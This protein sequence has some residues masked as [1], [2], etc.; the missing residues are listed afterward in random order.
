M[1]KETFL[2]TDRIKQ[3][4]SS[5]IKDGWVTIYE[6]Y[7]I[8]N[9]DEGLIYCCLVDS[10]RI[11]TYKQ[12]SDWV[13][14]IGSEGK[15]SIIET[16]KNSK[17]IVKYHTY[18]EKGI[19]PFVFSKHFSFSDGHDSYVD[20]SEEFILYFKLYEKGTDKQNRK[21]YFIDDGGD[22]EEVIIFEPKKVKVKVKYLI[23]YISV[24]KIYFA[25]CFDF[26]RLAKNNLSEL[27]IELKDTN[28]SSDLIYYNHLIRRLDFIDAGKNQSWI[29]G[30]VIIPFNKKKTK[31]YHFDYRNQE[32]A[33]FI[34]GY[35][36]K[37]NEI[38]QSCKKED[39]KHFVLT[40]FKKE[41]LNKYY[42]EP[43]KYEVDGFQVS[44]K[45]FIL[46]ID[47][48][49]ENYVPVFLIDLASLPYKEQLHWKQYNISPQKGISH[50]YYNTMINGNWA[51]HPETPDLYF[52]YKY[53]K[54]NS[55]W[56]KKFG[57]KFYK[58]SAE[59]DKHLFISLHIPTTNNVK[60]FCEQ[61]L[62]LVKLT[63]D[64]LNEAE[65]IKRIP[66][67]EK[68]DR[69]ITKLE[70]Y[71]QFEGVQIPE[72]I[73]FLRNLWDLRSGLLSHSFS[74]SNKDCK[75]AIA[76][77]GIKSDNYIDVAKDIFI[78]SVFTLNTL[79]RHLLY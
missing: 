22:L 70:K 35:D 40:Y 48:N 29:H 51:E 5:F 33:E 63:V 12:T 62:T 36:I 52:K 78:K 21:F 7:G 55:D 4:E 76:F 18:S 65:Y 60:A 13:I 69:G 57:W 49:I 39:G 44:S 6:S 41:V 24:R 30:K 43:T 8:D 50:S 23:E 79:E 19:E 17:P 10:K 61:M 59:E 73:I 25:I 77:F 66:N 47:N 42:N 72:M 46:R 38:L 3:I 31:S 27:S 16:Y 20:I 53:N 28:Y 71:L 14:N 67:L 26:M 75:K 2:F 74:N 15:P 64:R 34:T 56:E 11:K 1:E 9:D 58:P 37:G 32:Y 54:F 45:F 68:S